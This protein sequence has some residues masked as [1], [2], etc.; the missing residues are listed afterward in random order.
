MTNLRLNL[1]ITKPGQ[2]PITEFNIVHYWI[3]GAIFL[4][5]CGTLLLPGNYA[6]AQSAIVPDASLGTENS[7]VISNADV[8]GLPTEIIEGGAVRETNLF[9]SFTEFNIDVGRR[10][11]FASPKGIE[12]I[13]TRVTGE[14]SSAIDGTLGVLGN[15]DLFLL[16]PNGVIFGSNAQL[17]VAG[18]FMVS[19]ANSLGFEDGSEFSAVAPQE[20]LLTISVPLG[21]QLN[22]LPPQGD[23][24]NQAALAVGSGQT[25]TL[26]GDSITST[27]QLGAPGGTAQV[28]GNQIELVDSETTDLAGSLDDTT[29]IFR[30]ADGITVPDV[31]DDVLV[32]AGEIGSIELLADANGDGVGDVVMVDG[33]DALQT[34]GRNVAIAGV[35][36]ALG[37]IDTT[38]GKH[39]GGNIALTAE[40]NIT[41]GNMATFSFSDIDGENTADGGSIAIASMSGDISTEGLDTSSRA[42]GGHAGNG[43][44][45]TIITSGSGNITTNGNLDSSSRSESESESFPFIE[46]IFEAISDSGITGTDGANAITSDLDNIATNGNLGSIFDAIFNAT[47]SDASSTSDAGTIGIGGANAITSD[48]ASII[49]NGNL[50]AISDTI[51][52]TISDAIS[53]VIF[54]AIFSD[55]RTFSDSGIAG[56]GGAITITSDSGNITTNGNVDAFSRST[57]NSFS[58]SLFSNAS[59]SSN[60]GTVGNGGAIAITSNSGH[61]ITNRNMDASSRSNASS[62]SIFSASSSNS[63]TTGIGGAITITSDSGNI[64]INGELDSDSRSDASADAFSIS[65]SAADSASGNAGI[66]GAIAI[67][68]DSGNI[69]MNG[70]LNASSRSDASS[71]SASISDSTAHA[72]SGD[73][74]IGGTITTTSNSGNITINE[75]LNASSSSSSRAF[76]ASISSASISSTS[77]SGNAGTSGAIAITSDSGSITTNGDLDA[78]SRTTASATSDSDF[79]SDSDSSISSSSSSGRAGI[80]G[81][82]TITTSASGNITTNGPLESDSRSFSFADADADADV[83][84]ISASSVPGST[85]N[86]GVITITSDRGNITTKGRLDS[87]SSSSSF[88]S[89]SSESIPSSAVPGN[90]GDGGAIAITSQSGDI[91]MADELRSFSSSRFENAGNGGSISLE[92]PDGTIQGTNAPDGTIQDTTIRLLTFSLAEL[93]G[94]TGEGGDVNLEARGAISDLEVLTRSSRGQSGS[95]QIQGHGNLLIEEVDIVTSAQVEL[96]NPFGEDPII[97]EIDEV[98]QSGDISIASPGNITLSRVKIRSDANGDEPAGAVTLTSPG[99]ITFDSSQIN[100]NANQAGAGGTIIINAT[101]SVFLRKGVPDLDPIISVQA[102]GEGQPGNIVINTPTFVLS[103]TS[104]ITA[105]ATAT[106]TNENEGGSITLNASEMNLAGAVGIFAE[107]E[108][109]ASGGTLTL[110]PFDINFEQGE[111]QFAPELDVKLA[112][113]AEI[114]ASTSGSGQGGSLEIFAPEAI[115]IAGPGHLAVETQG[116]GN[117]G[118][119]VIRTQQLTLSDGVELSASTFADVPEKSGDAGDINIFANTFNL[120]NGATLQTNTV[121]TGNA[122]TIALTID[123]TLRLEQAEII[124]NT[125]ATTSGQGGDIKVEARVVQLNDSSLNVNSQGQGVGGDILVVTDSLFLE[126]ESAINAATASTDGG[127]VDLLLTNILLLS[128]QSKITATAGLTEGAGKGGSITIGVPSGFVIAL[129]NENNDITANAF[130]GRGGT[131]QITAQAIFGLTPRTFEELR[132]LLGTDNPSELDPGKLPTSDITAISQANPELSQQP[133]LNELGN[134]PNSNAVELPSDVGSPELAQGCQID[135]DRPQNTFVVTGRGGVPPLPNEALDDRDLDVGLVTLD[136]TRSDPRPRFSASSASSATLLPSP[137]IEAQGWTRDESGD[138]ALVVKAS[139]TESHQTWHSSHCQ[140]MTQAQTTR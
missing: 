109:P 63:G 4:S 47:F 134:R 61:I 60:S 15:A 39:S 95:V 127:N 51:S 28:V 12:T 52:D 101:E 35:N 128:D 94:T 100:S 25:L 24:I 13:L 108:G 31:V 119:I 26:F 117:G 22:A 27:V 53:D 116:E 62:L 124:A 84:S 54:D 38:N 67:T 55:A 120:T 19:T 71:D 102:R 126:Q 132:M 5:G 83:A 87:S 93:G 10:A 8:N 37:A 136:P 34:N 11:Y 75:D 59:T 64:T 48:L 121:G 65:D 91:T 42:N 111:P 125:R 89:S 41:T 68:S 56:N 21:L 131:I 50:A 82:I 130:L 80:G 113:G 43:G 99:Q 103:E 7:Q 138:I 33:Q 123:D 36:L 92:T 23:V 49:T 133:S 20:S 6:Y 73:A 14:N 110:Q 129:P 112:S 114:S 77:V 30:A 18:S 69:T 74:D 66:G 40:G 58:A 32:F 107:T 78:F 44:A 1:G 115:T 57:A 2:E 85:D 17:D 90:A 45:I 96:E 72:V 88:S 106:A 118:D 79:P 98:G 16:N 139:A 46:A 135:P 105:T 137:L 70:E 9:H 86:G 104:R 3:Y 97:L 76:S 122:G 29:L 140:A 81:A